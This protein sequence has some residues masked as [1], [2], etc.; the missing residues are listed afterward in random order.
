MWCVSAIVLRIYVF[1]TCTLAME[2]VGKPYAARDDAPRQTYSRQTACHCL[3]RRYLIRWM[4]SVQHF[5][6]AVDLQHNP[7][8]KSK[9]RW[10]LA[11]ACTLAGP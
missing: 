11:P 7:H 4:A 9:I 10:E 6:C 5:G 2:G 3:L 1:A 8:F